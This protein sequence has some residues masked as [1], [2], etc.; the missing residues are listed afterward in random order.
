MAEKIDLEKEFQFLGLLDK[1]REIYN[2][3]GDRSALAYVRSSIRVLSKVYHPDMNPEK[4]EKAHALQ[5]R[6]N[7]IHQILNEI[8]EDDLLNQI[9]IN[10]RQATRGKKKILVVEDE[11]GLQDF[12]RSV[13]S[14]EGY[15]T[16]SAVDGDD[17]YA[18]YKRFRPDLVLTDIVMPNLSG[19]ELVKKIRN[20]QSDIKVIY[21]SGFFGIKRLKQE[22]ENEILEYK[23]R[24][25]SKP[26]KISYMLDMVHEYLESDS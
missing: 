22:M 16:R 14:M 18:V 17:G 19:I 2:E 15:E 13:F 24:T 3:L 21:I 4:K 20:E 26:F 1:A 11:F 23:Y 6:I 25:L 5:S 10:F 12:L 7:R 8:N 9:K